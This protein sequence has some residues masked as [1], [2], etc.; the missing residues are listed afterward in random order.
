MILSYV[1]SP[2]FLSVTFILMQPQKVASWVGLE[3]EQRY[4]AYLIG[5]VLF[6]IIFILQ[7]MRGPEAR[8]PLAQQR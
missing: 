6:G 1:P 2:L 4:Y 3:H 7:R 8:L 5:L